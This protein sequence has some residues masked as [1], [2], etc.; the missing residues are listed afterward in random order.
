MDS[1]E[2]DDLVKRFAT[3][4]STTIEPKKSSVAEVKQNSIYDVVKSKI[5]LPGVYVI[6][7]L[8][9]DAVWIGETEKIWERMYCH[10][11]CFHDSN[12]IWA[13]ACSKHFPQYKDNPNFLK[14]E[15]ECFLVEFVVIKEGR[16]RRRAVEKFTDNQLRPYSPLLL[17]SR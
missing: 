7:T 5:G 13:L 15:V 12:L 8:C 3:L 17:N 1:G 10:I 4:G 14:K 11:H 2:R 6:R 16:K 9:G